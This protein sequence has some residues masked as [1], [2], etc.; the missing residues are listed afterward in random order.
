[1]NCV[2][3]IVI[4]GLELEDV[5]QAMRVGVEAAIKPGVKKI[6]AGNY[7]GGLG[8]YQIHLHKLLAKGEK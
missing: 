3:E 6:S 5:E 8:Q 7:G 2:L 1:M 4:D